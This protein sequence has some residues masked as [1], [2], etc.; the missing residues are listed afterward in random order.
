MH[1][2]SY[3]L[4]ALVSG[5]M[6]AVHI[7]API[8]DTLVRPPS[9]FSLT[10]P[11]NSTKLNLPPVLMNQWP[12]VKKSMELNPYILT[13]VQLH[14]RI[15]RYGL[16]F[17]LHYKGLVIS[18]LENIAT[19]LD[20]KASKSIESSP[21]ILTDHGVTFNFTSLDNRSLTYRS[22]HTFVFELIRVMILDGVREIRHAV[23]ELEDWEVQRH[24]AVG[25]KLAIDEPA[26]SKELRGVL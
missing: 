16:S 9:P 20:L 5:I 26:L 17:N 8:N 19:E 24:D 4:I 2:T 7:P 14:L 18:A 15:V 25:I 3:L 13:L 11:P 10:V 22:L 6:T 23:L 12:P 21:F 1:A